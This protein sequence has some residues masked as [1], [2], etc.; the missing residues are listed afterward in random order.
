M[1]KRLI[2][3]FVQKYYRSTRAFY[4]HQKSMKNLQLSLFL[5]TSV[6]T[7]LP[8]FAGI[9]STTGITQISAPTTADYPKSNSLQVFAEAGDVSFP[10]GGVNLD[11]GTIASGTS[12]DSYK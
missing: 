12:I 11:A 5:L 2:S 10:S 9:L 6:L 8:A 3:L 7:P 4:L 1:P